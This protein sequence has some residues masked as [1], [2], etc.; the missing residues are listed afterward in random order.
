MT[1]AI[2]S[3]VVHHHDG[4]SQFQYNVHISIDYVWILQ[5]KQRQG[6][7]YSVSIIS[8]IC[9]DFQS[10]YR[11]PRAE[12]PKTRSVHHARSGAPSTRSHTPTRAHTRAYIRK[13]HIC[14][15]NTFFL[16]Q[17]V[18]HQWFNNIKTNKRRRRFS[19]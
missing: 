7:Y 3:A 10:C 8:V 5:A 1:R 11:E 4:K 13:N 9:I 18:Q 15:S 12:T 19:D 14:L 17:N 6:T 2:A 16:V